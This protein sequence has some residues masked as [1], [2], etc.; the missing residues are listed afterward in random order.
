MV[1]A[2]EMTSNKSLDI[3]C[4]D[5]FDWHITDDKLESF[6]EISKQCV[7]QNNNWLVSLHWEFPLGMAT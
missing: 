3:E 5:Q 7:M 2:M 1:G 4:S 6:Q